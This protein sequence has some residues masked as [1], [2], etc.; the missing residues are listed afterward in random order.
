MPLSTPRLARRLSLA[1]I[2]VSVSLV[3]L[4]QAYSQEALSGSIRFS[5]YGGQLRNEKIDK[6]VTL[7]QERNPG[8]TINQEPLDWPSYWER[9]GV[10]AA[11]NN[12]PCVIGMLPFNIAEYA[13]RN[14]LADMQPLVDSGAIS[15]DDIS[16]D[17]IAASRWSD[18]KLLML[19]YGA[20]PDTITYNATMVEAAG[21]E[22]LPE[23]YDWDQFF[24]WL[25]AAKAQLRADVWSIDSPAN[26]PDLLL[27]YIGSHGYKV[28][29]GETLG[30][31]KELLVAWF[32]EW[33]DLNAAGA[34]VPPDMIAEEPGAHELSYFAG[35]R[36]LVSQRP[37]NALAALQGGVTSRGSADLLA[38]QLYPV[39]PEGVGDFVPVNS[40]SVAA[41][42]DNI[43]LAAAFAD[44][45]LNDP[46]AGAIFASD[47]G[48]V[49]NAVLLQT[50]VE[51][52]DT[53][54]PTRALL[55]TFQQVNA[56]GSVAQTFPPRFQARFTEVHK[57]LMM[58]VLFGSLTPQ[59]AADT[60]FSE[61]E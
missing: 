61:A 11:G 25:L 17:L 5:W 46:E 30:F 50:Q 26:N 51:S 9:L 36:S 35:S 38:T 8:T 58:E 28:Y 31:P 45:F 42:C 59:E 33:H 55:E 22:L 10:Q 18:G 27:A 39:G 20:A 6:M 21:I 40:L 49:T 1:A 44:F 16:P 3:P 53:P 19:P 37:A 43:P 23:G 56:R 57:R 14:L 54:A 29:E 52:A 34:M 48:A 24:D 7:F 2:V 41:A 60:F 4:S 15:L 32:T 47:N 12:M 13:G